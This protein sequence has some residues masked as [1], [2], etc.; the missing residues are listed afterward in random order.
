[1]GVMSAAGGAD[2]GGALGARQA[3]NS[4]ARM[5]APKKGRARRLGDCQAQ[6]RV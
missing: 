4:R 3:V 1:M 6:E 5:K 2:V